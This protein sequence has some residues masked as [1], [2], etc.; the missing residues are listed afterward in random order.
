MAVL[1]GLNI[2]NI[3]LI[4]KS[5]V[6]IVIISNAILMLTNIGFTQEKILRRNAILAKMLTMDLTYFQ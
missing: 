3:V 2:A 5:I 1:K 6:L 4:T